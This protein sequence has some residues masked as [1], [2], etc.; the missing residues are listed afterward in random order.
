VRPERLL[1][2]VRL[3]PS[4]PPSLCSGVPLGQGAEWSNSTASPGRDPKL[5][6]HANKKWARCG[7]IF[8]SYGAPGEIRTPGLLVRS[9][10]LYPT[11]L[12]AQRHID[13]TSLEAVSPVV[14]QRVGQKPAPLAYTWRRGRD[15]NPRRAFDPYALSRGAP[16][17]TRPPL[18]ITAIRLFAERGMI[19]ARSSLGKANGV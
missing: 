12:R 8:Y 1:G 2:A 15:S 17:T 10:A 3:V 13:K 11:E 6:L 19:P 16:S 18:R 5:V 14:R 7:P 4:G 9:Q